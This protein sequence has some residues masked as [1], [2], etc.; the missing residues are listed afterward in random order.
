MADPTDLLDR[1]AAKLELRPHGW[2]RMLELARR[3][4]RRRRLFAGTLA[5]VLSATSGAGLWAAFHGT[6]Q[7]VGGV[8]N[9]DAVARLDRAISSVDSTRRTVRSELRRDAESLHATEALVSQL[10]GQL[11][12]IDGEAERARVQAQIQSKSAQV[13][14]LRAHISKLQEELSVAAERLASLKVRRAELTFPPSI[15]PS[16]ASFPPWGNPGGCPS[17]DGVQPPGLRAIAEILPNLSRL[18]TESID[19]DLF[20]ADRAYWPI[21]QATWS[22]GGLPG[23]VRTLTAEGVTSGPA[24]RSP[25]A[26]LVRGSCGR[27]TL[28]LSWWVAVCPVETTTC[29]P[30]EAPALTEHFLLVDRRGRW[31]V[32]FE[33]P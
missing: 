13:A 12:T 32:W 19:T 5:L 15:Y 31:L 10:Q 26:G 30:R 11:A 9:R 18:G 17:L 29:S 22:T 6:P 7:Q 23:R 24:A 14:E 4:Q 16:A 25:Y 21:L 20:L 2:E 1:E 28:D 3:R 8:S 33:N 27:R